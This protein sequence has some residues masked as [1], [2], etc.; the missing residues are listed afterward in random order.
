MPP[1]APLAFEIIRYEEASGRTTH[2]THP[3]GNPGGDV[4]R[5]ALDIVQ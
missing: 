5:F 1:D 4:L 2:F 3:D